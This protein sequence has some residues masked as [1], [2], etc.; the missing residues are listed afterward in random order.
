MADAK[1]TALTELTAVEATDLLYVIDD[2]AGTPAG[3]KATVENVMAA[4]GLQRSMGRWDAMPSTGG[5]GYGLSVTGNSGSTSGTGGSS[6]ANYTLTSAE[7]TNSEAA[8]QLQNNLSC[9]MT[10]RPWFYVRFRVGKTAATR[11]FAYI[12]R[13][14]GSL[15]SD[16]P[17]DGV[18]G[19]RDY[20]GVRLSSAASDTNFMFVHN[21]GGG[22]ETYD[23]GVAAGTGTHTL[24]VVMLSASTII[25]FDTAVHTFAHTPGTISVAPIVKSRTLEDVAT[26]ITIEG[27]VGGYIPGGA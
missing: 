22:Q 6:P 14:N 4:L 12:G 23:T 5:A 10:W 1:V 21:D 19:G 17:L 26:T 16:D 8:Y 20:A 27:M 15:A 9:P 7:T 18:F 11:T 24:L 25:K 13:L 3:K 2:P